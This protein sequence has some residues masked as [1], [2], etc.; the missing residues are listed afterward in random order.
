MSLWDT[1]L[2]KYAEA[3][4]VEIWTFLSGFLQLLEFTGCPVAFSSACCQD[5]YEW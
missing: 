2:P 1:F 5:T 3:I 4:E